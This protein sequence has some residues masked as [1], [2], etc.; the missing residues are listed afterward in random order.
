MTEHLSVQDPDEYSDEDMMRFAERLFSPLTPAEE[1]ER[2]CMLLAHL[3]TDAAQ[4]LLRRFRESAR[5]EEVVWIE[6]AAEEGAFHL[7]EAQNDLEEQEFLMLK[8]IEELEDE[9]LDLTARR[10]QL[11]LQRRKSELRGS[12]IKALVA[13]RRL[14]PDESLGLDDALL[15]LNND[16]AEIDAR[17]EVQETVARYLQDSITTPRYKDVDPRVIRH[18]H[19]D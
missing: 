4:R 5:A 14:D 9:I 6:T 16:I 11:D 7:L 19:L 15:C 12:A 2:I 3:P 18:I 8:V 10:D 13:E 1:L 17:L